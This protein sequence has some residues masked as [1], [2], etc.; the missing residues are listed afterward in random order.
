[1]RVSASGSSPFYYTLATAY[2]WKSF[3]I[4]YRTPF[5]NRTSAINRATCREGYHT[6]TQQFRALKLVICQFYDNSD[7]WIHSMSYSLMCLMRRH[8]HIASVKIDT[9][10]LESVWV[11]KMRIE[12]ISVQSSQESALLCHI[13]I[14]LR[15]SVV[16]VR[17]VECS[18]V[19]TKLDTSTRFLRILFVYDAIRVLSSLGSTRQTRRHLNTLCNVSTIRKRISFSKNGMSPAAIWN[20]SFLIS[21]ALR[22]WWMWK[23]AVT[24][25][26]CRTSVVMT[27]LS[28]KTLDIA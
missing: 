15:C 27:F 17:Q 13:S 1:M 11:R 18:T 8:I 26:L 19:L 28:L 9:L 6:I 21:R 14:S 16:W 10:R 4:R 25:A 23:S 22:I 24:S 20:R 12:A 5:Q 2:I 7:I 3:L